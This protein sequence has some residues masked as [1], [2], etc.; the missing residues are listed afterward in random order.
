MLDRFGRNIDYIRISVTDRCNLRCVY[1]MPEEGVPQ[2]P[3]GEILTYDEIEEICRVLSGMGISKIKITGGE[4]LV[5]KG[6]PFLIERLKNLP[7]IHQVTLTTNGCLLKEQLPALIKA[8]IDGIN[9]SIDTLN[10][11]KYREITR[12]GDLKQAMEG[13]HA[14]VKADACPVKVNCVPVYG[15]EKEELLSV[16]R[17]AREN[18]VHV[19]F[20]E[21][22]PIGWGRNYLQLPE[23][24]IKK[25]L[26]EVYGELVPYEQVLGNGPG[27]YY[28]LKGFQGKIGFISAV[29][30]KF[31]DSCN[32]VRL[33]SEGFLKTCLQYSCGADLKPL[34]RENEDRE[35]RMEA[36]ETAIFQALQEKPACHHF[37]EEV[38]GDTERKGMSRIGG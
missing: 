10:E 18:P 24:E 2:I 38:Q 17:L 1:C 35:K 31:C 8:G 16:V 19:R 11:E 15:E 33:T 37:G 29:S 21:M 26:E 6:L 20:I 25:V 30:H 9:I 36:L 5:R 13:F 34:I 3:H 4:P 14:A 7:G 12:G 23:E 28:T 32:R 22:M 27:H